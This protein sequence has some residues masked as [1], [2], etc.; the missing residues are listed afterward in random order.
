MSWGK[1][2]VVDNFVTLGDGEA[3]VS[4]TGG[5]L[6]RFVENNHFA[7]P[8]TDYEFVGK[9]GALAVLSGSA[10]LARQIHAE[11]LGKFFKAEFEGWGSSGKGKFKKIAVYIWNGE[12]NEAMKAWPK[13]SEYYGK[14][15]SNG[16]SAKE[17]AKKV[18]DDFDDFANP[19]KQLQD[20]TDDLPF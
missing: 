12:P 19:P 5:I 9:D 18:R 8:K 10:S 17:T 20:D 2:E 4:K 14:A 13:F 15:A 11:D 1:R 6:T 3:D 7:Q 16:A